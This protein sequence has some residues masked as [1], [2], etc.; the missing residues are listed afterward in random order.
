VTH[1][2]T[3]LGIGAIG[4]SAG[5]LVLLLGGQRR[6]PQILEA[7]DWMTLV[8]FGALF[9][10]VGALEQTGALARAADLLL[11]ASGGHLGPA[12]VILLWFGAVGSA[13][14]DN[15]PFAATMAPVIGHLAAAG[16]PVRPLVWATA[17]GT[18]IGGNATPIGASAN[19][20]G[21]ASYERATGNR[22]TWGEYL[23][24]AVPATLVVVASLQVFLLLVHA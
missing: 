3:H 13:I 4:V 15:V 17:L 7:V 6:M 14:V 19:V 8:F 12:L 18:D 1:N 5:A 10:I 21:I 23:K 9:L 24:A 11:R 16:L 22:V 20:V 2:L